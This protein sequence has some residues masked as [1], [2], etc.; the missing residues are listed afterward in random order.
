MDVRAPASPNKR[1]GTWGGR[2][3]EQRRAE[4]RTRLIEAALT[5]W[6]ENGW[7]A[8]TMR[9]V[10]TRAGLNDRYFYEHFADRD[11]LLAVVWDEVCFEVFGEL[12]AL[13]AEHVELAALDILHLAVARAVDLQTAGPARILFGNHAGSRILEERRKAMLTEA[14]D[15]LI[16]TARPYLRPGVDESDLRMGVLMGIGGFVELLTAWRMGAIEAD[17]SRIIDHVNATADL[18]GARYLALPE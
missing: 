11:E 3:Q 12:S 16:A 1:G 7:A 14:T 4:R 18:L 6:L 5:I 8:V 13:V 2:T 9:G 17:T 10:C 15:L